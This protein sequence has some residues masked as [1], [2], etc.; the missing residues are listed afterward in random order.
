MPTLQPIAYGPRHTGPPTPRL[1]MREPG[2]AP[3]PVD[4]A[5]WPRTGNPATELRQLV[6]ALAARLGPMARVGFDWIA[7]DPTLLDSHAPTDATRAGIMYLYGRAG[8]RLDVLV[9]PAHT[10]PALAARQMRWASGKPW[11]TGRS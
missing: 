1:T 7:A 2:S 6:T 4:G 11:R 8:T 10:R 9:I 3:G 5:W